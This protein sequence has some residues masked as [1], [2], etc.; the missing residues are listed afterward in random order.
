M[1]DT[2]PTSIEHIKAGEL[3]A[4]GVTSATRS[5]ILPDVP[6]IAEFIPGYEASGWQGI[7]APSQ[8][9][10]D[11]VD[12]LHREINACLA[13]ANISARIADFGSSVFISTQPEFSQFV[14]ESG[15]EK[16][17]R[18]IWTANIKLN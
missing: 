2:L 18:V 16:W 8:T 13:D 11:I 1:F 4:L 12:R 10:A 9:P 7:G 3:R 15:L 6:A 17:A 5:E 14:V